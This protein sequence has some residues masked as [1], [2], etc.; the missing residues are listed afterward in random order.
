MGVL[1]VLHLAAAASADP[2]LE[3]ARAAVI[4]PRLDLSPAD[5]A[6]LSHRTTSTRHGCEQV[7]TAPFFEI[8]Q[9]SERRVAY[10]PRF[11]LRFRLAV[12]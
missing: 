12:R 8:A 7:P 6:C 10:C 3:G 11:S 4:R 2:L 9:Y 5:T 1:C